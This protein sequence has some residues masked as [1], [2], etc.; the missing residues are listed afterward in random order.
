M[1]EW[2]RIS[3]TKIHDESY[4]RHKPHLQYFRELYD[5]ALKFENERFYEDQLGQLRIDATFVVVCSFL[6]E[7]QKLFIKK[8]MSFHYASIE[9]P[10]RKDKSLFTRLYIQLRS[11][12][13]EN[14][15][16]LD[17]SSVEESHFFLNNRL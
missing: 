16:L 8:G 4:T 15:M 3:I 10:D 7:M 2:K 9:M 1:N 12:N 11:K 13:N 14:R 5:N 17:I 6:A